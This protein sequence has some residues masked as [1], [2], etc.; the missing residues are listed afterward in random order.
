VNG[1]TFFASGLVIQDLGYM[2]I[3]QYDRWTNKELPHYQEGELIPKFVVAIKD[4][5]TTAPPLLTEADLISLMDRHGIGTDAT[6]ADHIEKIKVRKYVELNRE[7]RFYPTFMGLALV[8]GYNRMGQEPMSRPLLRAE[9]ERQL[10]GI[11]EGTFSILDWVG[12]SLLRYQIS[13]RQTK[14][15]VLEAQLRVYRDIFTVAERDIDNLSVSLHQFMSNM[16]QPN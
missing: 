15:Q 11:C 1:E 4:G 14:A 16:P 8:D 6:H 10:V 12:N 7:Q 3:Y 2:L 5:H 9:L 13:G